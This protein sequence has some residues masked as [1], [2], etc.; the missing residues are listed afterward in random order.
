MREIKFR[1]WSITGE[2]MYRWEDMLKDHMLYKY[3]KWD[4]V[5]HLMQYT[6]LKD[7]NGK[8]IYE[9]DI[10]KTTALTNTY[11]ERGAI[12]KSPVEIWK[13]NACLS[14]TY[15]PIY[16]FCVNH[17]IEVIGNVH[18]HPELLEVQGE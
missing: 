12:V 18:E 8:E 10:V 3:F 1:A 16:P 15:I 4:E 14:V 17:K 9:G 2:F 13:G 7:V 5:Y 6:G 11:N